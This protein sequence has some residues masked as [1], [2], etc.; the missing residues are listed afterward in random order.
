MVFCVTSQTE[1]KGTEW[2]VGIFTCQLKEE[3]TRAEISIAPSSS[4]QMLQM[5]FNKEKKVRE[6]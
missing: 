4:L 3:R 5:F 1:G 2:T 6:K